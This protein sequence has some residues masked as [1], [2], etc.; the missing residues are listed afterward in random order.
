MDLQERT[1][2]AAI[3]AIKGVGNRSLWNL[4]EEFGS[5]QAVLSADRERLM[6]FKLPDEVVK[7]ILNLPK[8]GELELQLKKIDQQA[9]NLVTFEDEDYPQLLRDISNPP[10]VLYIKGDIE[11]V[12]HLCLAIVGSRTATTYGKMAARK[13][14]LEL[15][16]NNAAVISGMA[17]GIDTEAH[18]GALE[19]NGVTIAVLGSGMDVVYPPENQR[20]F[21]RIS[22]NGLV[23]SEFPLGTAPEPGNF[24]ARN[25]IISGLSRGVIVVEAMEKSGALIT[26]DFALEQ[27]RDVFAVPGPIN[28]KTSTGTNNL[29]KQGA[30]L[31]TSVEDVLEEYFFHKNEKEMSSLQQPKL[32]ML[33]KNEQMIVE[34]IESQPVHFD[35]ILAATGFEI[36]LLSTVLLKLEFEGI[37]KSLP[38]NSYVKIF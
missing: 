12:G 24:P 17:R 37:I 10:Y 11:A 18:L 28:S 29:I 36:G 30:K 34:C 35:A 31:I 21:H 3:H 23:I 19:G 20:L 33:D 25:R 2:L 32:L 13:F 26:A 9:V 8:S 7:A 22:E 38:G 5:F 6:R 1:V 14:S 15:A 27:G 4:K 16:Q